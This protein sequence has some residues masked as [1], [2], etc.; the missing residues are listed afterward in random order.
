MH[1]E[2]DFA[3]D[4]VIED[5]VLSDKPRI[6]LMGLQRS[7]KSSIQRVVFGKMPPNDTLYL[8]STTKIQKEDIAR[9]FIDFQIWDFPGQIDFFDEMA[10]DPQDIFGTVGALIFVIDAQDDYSE[11]LHRLFTTVTSAYRVN[12]NI[13]FEVLIHKVDG[14]S[15]DYKIDTQRDV[16]QRMSDALADAQLEYIHLTY[17]LTSIYDNSIYEAFSKIIQKLIREL[18]ALE[19]LLNVL[20]SNSGIDKAYLFDTLTKI[21]IA[22]DSSPVDMQSYELCSDMIDV[23]I[24]VECIYGAQGGSPMNLSLMDSTE[25]YHQEITNGNGI[26]SESVIEQQEEEKPKQYETEAS[27][28]IKLDNGDVLYMREVNR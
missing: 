27:S 15:D 2:S 1:N 6:L 28:L 4:T 16:Q 13:T 5:Q 23:C 25:R 18:P 11:A 9:S 12:P 10:Y 26:D 19:N 17:Y 8:E 21:Y 7:G 22:T 14:L 20:C 3:T 24:D